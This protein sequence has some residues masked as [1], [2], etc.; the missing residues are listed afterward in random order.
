[1]TALIVERPGAIKLGVLPPLALYV[2]IPWCVR[3]CPYCDF[4]SHERTGSLPQ[5]Q[6][7]A[8]LLDDLEE[9]VPSVWGRRVI[10][11]FIGGGTPSL[12][13]PESID[14]LLSGIRARVTLEPGAE[15]TLEANPG[16]VEAARFAGFRQAGVNRISLGVQ[17]FDEG[18]LARLGRIHGADEA[19][20]AI[21]AARASF[22]N[23]NID[24]MYGLPEQTLEMARADI[25]QAA[26]AG[27]PHVSAYQLTI[28]P[29]TVFW[30]RRPP[31]PE[32]D[33]CADMQ[34]AVEAA[35]GEAGF[36]HYETSAFAQPGRRGQHN[37]NYWQFGDYLGIGAGA[38]GKIS[39]PE[40]IMRHQRVK[41]PQE[42][43]DRPSTL[44]AERA[45]PTA[46]VPFEFMLNA[47]RLVEGFPVTLFQQRT[48]LPLTLLEPQLLNAEKQGL[49]ERDWQRIRPS[50]R[51]G[52]FLNELL[53]LFLAG[54]SKDRG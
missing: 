45:I 19:R 3:K 29:N 10:S 44:V 49:L 43:L 8:K 23:V 13:A 21:E 47:L 53:E 46:E 22:D 37:L 2:H 41:Q 35:L 32:H 16:T 6:Y 26:R 7:V 38:H 54:E 11:V 1:M 24:L 15:I 4:N 14:S 12:F 42:Y 20:R 18:M 9:L 51:G 48:G 34:L 39:F 52:R 40:R 28:E 5:S 33:A 36:E 17:S 25:A 27:V 31:L 50:E 30:R